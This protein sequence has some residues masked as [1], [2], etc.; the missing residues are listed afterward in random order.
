[1]DEETAHDLILALGETAAERLLTAD[2]AFLLGQLLASLRM[3]IEARMLGKR[4]RY[5]VISEAQFKEQL[6]RQK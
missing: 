5:Y 2:E 6:E 4:G 1:M 3:A